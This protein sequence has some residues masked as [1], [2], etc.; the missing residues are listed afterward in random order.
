MVMDY[1]SQGPAA[2]AISIVFAVMTGVVISLR[3]FSR[4]YIVRSTGLDDILMVIAAVLSWAFIAM[5]V[6]AVNHGLGAHYEVVLQRGPENFLTYLKIV[7]FSSI[8]YNATLCFIKLSVLALY[9]RLGDEI[10]RRMSIG[11][12]G[13]IACQ[14][15]AFV[16]TCIFQCSP[17]RGA[18]EPTMT[19]APVC[20]NINA[21]YLSNAAL[22]I[23]TD[24]ITYALPV[25]MI[26]NLQTPLKQKIAVG[27]MFS[28]GFFACI[29]SIVRM[30][31][32]PSMLVSTDPTWAIGPPMYWSVIETN[33]GI[34]AASIPSFKPIARRYLP[35]IIGEYSSGGRSYPGASSSRNFGKISNTGGEWAGSMPMKPV[36]ARDGIT[37]TVITSRGDGLEDLSKTSSG[38]EQSLVS[39]TGRITQSTQIS[40][41]VENS[42]L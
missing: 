27:V 21:F 9:M 37:T 15:I 30:T 36:H 32:V 5:T 20:V 33:I 38:S 14:G 8:F 6:L 24:L 42:R 19:P 10:L 31:F 1:G 7:Y 12:M 2:T 41:K 11:M 34:L 28:L 22:N 17:V 39:N 29:S 35:R 18:W 40:Q 13:V 25:R 23:V 4:I 3:L 16:L 26:L